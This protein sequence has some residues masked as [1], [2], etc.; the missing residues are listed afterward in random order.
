[1]NWEAIGAIGENLGA[2][3]VLVTL[4]YLANQ[5]RYAKNAAA[6][7]NRIARAKGVCDLNLAFAQNPALHKANTKANR[8]QGWY[9]VL[10]DELG[11]SVEE[12]ERADSISV[13][14]IWLHWSQFA[15]TNR[16]EDLAELRETVGSFYASS[17]AIKYAWNH[18]PFS[19]PIMG[20]AFISFVDQA[21]AG[22]AEQD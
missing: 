18:G 10:A 8:Y 16:E 7:A 3:L 22:Y 9:E 5:V 12:A 11:I 2:V 1:M 15:G 21:I 14:W 6:D 13:Y 17:P 4:I 20:K 19:K